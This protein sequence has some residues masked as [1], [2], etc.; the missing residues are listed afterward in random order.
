MCNPTLQ[1]FSKRTVKGQGR[2]T[3]GNNSE[4]CEEDTKKQEAKEGD[5][6]QHLLSRFSAVSKKLKKVYCGI[7]DVIDDYHGLIKVV[8]DT[9]KEFEIYENESREYKT[10]VS[11]KKKTKLQVDESQDGEVQLSGRDNFNVILDNFDFELQNRFSLTE[12]GNLN[13]SKNQSTLLGTN[14]SHLPTSSQN[15]K[16]AVQEHELFPSSPQPGLSDRPDVCILPAEDDSVE[17]AILLTTTQSA[18]GKSDTE[19]HSKA[20]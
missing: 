18:E 14:P 10:T 12:L 7:A 4:G 9:R 11:R 16:P 15:S 6:K 5:L 13:H 17:T 2:I 3:G 1:T 20:H 19:L 8:T